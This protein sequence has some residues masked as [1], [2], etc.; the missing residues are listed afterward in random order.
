MTS[1][2][3]RAVPATHANA[4]CM[5]W[6]RHGTSAKISYN[7]WSKARAG[8]TQQ[9]RSQDD[10]MFDWVSMCDARLRP[11]DATG[12]VIRPATMC[13]SAGTGRGNRILACELKIADFC[14]TYKVARLQLSR[15]AEVHPVRSWAA[16]K[17]IRLRVTQA[18][19]EAVRGSWQGLHGC[20]LPS[21]PH[22]RGCA[23]RAHEN[24]LQCCRRG[25]CIEH[26]RRAIAELLYRKVVS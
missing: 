21:Q 4:S 5:E 14:S 15:S 2:K 11:R 13:G 16:P 9:S 10:P 18:R 6:Q 23:A 19:G 12:K 24:C 25:P 3:F 26:P 20:K 22:S 1:W 8:L 7:H 17:Q